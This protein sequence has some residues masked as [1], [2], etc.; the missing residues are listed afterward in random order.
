MMH[1][2][3]RPR[4][5]RDG[6]RFPIR[7][8]ESGPAGG[9]ILAAGIAR[10]CGLDKVL[11]FDMGGTTAKICLIDDGE[12]QHSRTFEVARQYRFL[13]GS[14][15]PMRIPV[16]EMVE[17]GAG[18]G[19]IARV[20]ALQ[21]HHRS[22]RRA[23][24][25]SRVRPATAAAAPRRPSPMPTSCWAASIPS[26]SPAARSSS[27]PRPARRRIDKAG[28]HAAWHSTRRSTRLRRQRDR[29]GEHGQCRPRP[30]RR[31]RQGAAGPHH[32]RLRRR[33]AAACRAARREARHQ[34]RHGAARRGRRLGGRLPAAPVAYEVVRS[35]YVQLDA[36]KFD[37]AFVN[38]L[39]ARDARRGRGRREGR[40]ADRQAGGDRA[41]PT[42]AIAARATRSP[43]TCRDGDFTR[44]RG[45]VAGEALRGGLRRDLRPDHPRPFGRDHEL[46][47]AARRRAAADAQGAAAAAGHAGQGARPARRLRSGRSGHEGR[48]GLSSRRPARPAATFPGPAIIAEDETTTIVPTS[49]AARL[50]PDRRTSCWRSV[51]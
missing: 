29:R 11:S 49:F 26:S 30:C 45:R 33:R 39:F 43:S 15:L 1:L 18:G 24:A 2:G 25:P 13:K 12:P 7:L 17:I 20:D 31:A 47:A 51:Q 46:D 50:R 27:T 32:D 36:D 48:V 4:H 16:I 10:Q 34:P 6:A 5:A 3:R 21:P 40:R 35:R 14:G 38:A 42:C 37:P 41:P 9:A 44:R 22:A 8:V 23:P 19:S 28:R